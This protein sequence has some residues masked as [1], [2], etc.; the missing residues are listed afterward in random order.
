MDRAWAAPLWGQHLWGSWSSRARGER[1][2]IHP[3]NSLKTKQSWKQPLF[4]QFL[5]SAATRTSEH[6]LGS[7]VMAPQPPPISSPL[8]SLQPGRSQPCSVCSCCSFVGWCW[9]QH[10]SKLLVSS[11]VT[12]LLMQGHGGARAGRVAALRAG[13][14]SELSSRDSRAPGSATLLWWFGCALSPWPF[15]SCLLPWDHFSASTS[16]M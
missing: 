5:L 14:A 13:G 4:Q 10:H 12:E 15:T 9:C 8:S 1:A 6:R 7:E 2:F 3:R 16:S 11:F